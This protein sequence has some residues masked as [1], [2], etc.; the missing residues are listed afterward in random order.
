[1]RKITIPLLALLLMLTFTGCSKSSSDRTLH[2][3]NWTYYMPDS[4]VAQFEEETGIRIVQDYFSSNEEMFA[5]LQAGG[6]TGFDIVFPSADYTSI[7]IKLGML[8]E[9]DHDKVPNLQYITDLVKEK[10]TYDPEMNYSVPYFMGAAGI[11]VN[12]TRVDFDYDRSWMIFADERLRGRMTLLDDMREVLGDALHELG[13]S[14]NTTD[15]EELRQAADIVENQW[16]PNIVKFDAE[17]FAKSFASGEFYVVHCYPENVFEEVAEEDWD[18]IDF[19]LP[20]EGGNMY[21][22]NMVILKTSEHYEEA[23]EFINFIHRP[24]IYAEF[25]DEFNFPPTTNWAAE[26][27]MTTTPVFTAEDMANYEILIDVGEDLEKYNTLWQD[28]RYTN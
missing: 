15:D 25:L 3:Y 7:M 11:A 14:S 17:S 20:A 13:Y 23:L 2:L 28:I 18:D 4:I 24:E 9:I 12:K 27:Y 16:K 1:M 6:G 8:A 21:V 10:A 19:F 5:K 26:E 22:D